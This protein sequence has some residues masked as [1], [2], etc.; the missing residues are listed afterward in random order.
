MSSSSNQ[1]REQ[2]IEQQ[3]RAWEVL[4]ARVLSVLRNVPREQFVPD[5]HRYLAFA[6]VN[7]PL[8]HGQHMLRPNIA[9]RLLQALE[10]SGTERVLEIGAGTGFVTACLAAA[11]AHVRS[12]EL[13]ADL[14][15]RA[16]ANLTA[17]GAANVD[18]VTADA[19]QAGVQLEPSAGGGSPRYHAIA[20][21]GSLPVYDERF[22]RLLEVGGRLFVIVGD[23]PVME[24]RLVRRV[25]EDGWVTESLFETVVDP[26]VNARRPPGF[27][28]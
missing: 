18:V 12:L 9:G 5:S 20:V 25:A 14:A 1:A 2:M 6:D 11:S 26:L 19:M 15:D 23:A 17:V 21:T 28:F 27:S 7:V 10:L 24:A 4:D 13:F 8:P 16:R 22:Q 3:V